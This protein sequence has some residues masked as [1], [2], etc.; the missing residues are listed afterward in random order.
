MF[1]FLIFARVRGYPPALEPPKRTAVVSALTRIGAAPSP[2]QAKE[3]A[4][5][6]ASQGRAGWSSPRPFPGMR[7]YWPKSG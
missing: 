5:K 2:G 6:E 4:A 1:S 3:G 7:S